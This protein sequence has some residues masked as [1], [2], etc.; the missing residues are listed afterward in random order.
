M[1]IGS[2]RLGDIISVFPIPR[3]SL[4][5]SVRGM[6]PPSANSPILPRPIVSAEVWHEA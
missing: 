1:Q 6:A 4:A 2:C 3:S 5:S